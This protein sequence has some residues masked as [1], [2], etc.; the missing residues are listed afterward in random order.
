MDFTNKTIL[1]VGASSGI[2][3]QI[4]IDLDTNGANLILVSRKKEKLTS[5]KKTLA[6]DNHAVIECDI[7]SQS[8]L[9]SLCADI[10]DNMAPLD[11]M[12][13]SAGTSKTKSL[14][15]I[16]YADYQAIFDVNVYPA[17]H[18]TAFLSGKGMHTEGSSIVYICSIGSVRG[19]SGTAIYSASKGALAAFSRT[20]AVELSRKNMRVNCISPGWT[21]S[22]MTESIENK[23]PSLMERMETQ[24][25]LGFGHVEDTSNMACYLLSPKARWITG[26]NIIVDGGATSWI[27]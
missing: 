11:G 22:P 9:F 21:H 3:R 24:Y 23:F 7:S 13:F 2:G 20:A 17:M 16:S 27:L 18:L 25:P 4:A 10:K 5:L 19:T 12:V 15:T 6:N 8:A 26:Q 14:H 1:V